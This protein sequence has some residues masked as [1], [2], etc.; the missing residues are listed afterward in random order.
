MRSVEGNTDVVIDPRVEFID[1]DGFMTD[2]Q[3]PKSTLMMLVAALI[4]KDQLDQIY[5]HAV[6]QEYRFFSYGDTSLLFPQ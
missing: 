3:L 5:A 1:A 4:G 6:T 2:F